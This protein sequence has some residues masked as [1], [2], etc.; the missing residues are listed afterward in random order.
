VTEEC[1]VG[2]YGEVP[3]NFD[4]AL[5]LAEVAEEWRVIADFPTFFAFR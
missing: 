3:G 1:S 5:D 2:L 4:A